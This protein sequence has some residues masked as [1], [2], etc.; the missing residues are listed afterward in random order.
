MT[1]VSP[2]PQDAPA[3]V[4]D[5]ERG[6]IGKVD[7]DVQV[8]APVPRA[9]AVGVAGVLQVQGRRGGGDEPGIAAP[10]PD[11]VLVG[12]MD[13][14]TPVRQLRG[15]VREGRPDGVVP[16]DPFFMTTPCGA[17][18][19]SSTRPPCDGSTTAAR[20]RTGGP[21]STPRWA[22]WKELS[23]TGPR[24]PG[25]FRAGPVSP[26]GGRGPRRR[27]PPCRSHPSTRR[28]PGSGPGPHPAA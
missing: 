6:R 5:G 25:P 16:V 2:F 26:P 18:S 3:R 21:S 9:G 28:P 11:E 23:A 22:P 10:Q 13:V 17:T 14:P 12:A 27:T 4:P 1:P 8:V 15:G 24:D 20:R 19:V 7:R